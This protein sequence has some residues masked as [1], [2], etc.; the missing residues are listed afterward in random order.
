M[1]KRIF[2]IVSFV[3]TCFVLIYVPIFAI[4]QAKNHEIYT[5]QN[6]ETKIYTIWHVET[7]EGGSAPR[8][9]YLKKIARSLEKTHA[10]TLFLIK[11]I[12]AEKLNESLKES[13]P[14]IISFGFGVGKVVLPYLTELNTCFGVRNELV[15][16]SLFNNKVYALPYIASGYAL[17]TN[18]ILT[19]N[20]HYGLTGYTHPEN[21]CENLNLQQSEDETQYKAYKSFVYGKDVTL[22][23]T[24]RD[25]FRVENLNKVG[26]KNASITPNSEYTDLLQY[27]G[28]TKTDETIKEFLTAMFDDK[29]QQTLADFGL[30]GVKN[31]KIYNSGIYDE[32]ENAIFACQIAKVFDEQN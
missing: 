6:V 17:I 26:R 19:Q 21:A 4:G 28:I 16:A 12:E 13:V 31:T 23:G 18:G 8:I 27:V 5:E 32:M 3:V 14:D 1:K 10:G 2:K 11:Q 24:A 22:F 30:F 20:L 25:V 9:N 29:T 15:E 7:F